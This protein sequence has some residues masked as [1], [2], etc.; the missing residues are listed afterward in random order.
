MISLRSFANQLGIVNLVV[1]YTTQGVMALNEE[2]PNAS[3]GKTACLQPLFSPDPQ[4]N[5]TGCI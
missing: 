5:F 3:W 4:M 1:D 2:V